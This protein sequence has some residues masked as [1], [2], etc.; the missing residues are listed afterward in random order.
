MEK[1][2][3]L[4]E[5]KP[6]P[7]LVFGY[8]RVSTTDQNTERQKQLLLE[9]FPNQL[10]RIYEDTASGK[11]FNHRPNFQLLL[12]TVRTNDTIVVESFSR[13]SRNSADL[14]KL[15]NDFEEKQIT[16]ISL[17]ENFDFKTPTGK[18]M[19]TLLVGLT[20][21]ERELLLERQKEGILL[22]KAAGKYKGRKKIKKPSNFEDCLKMYLNREN[23]YRIK[24]FMLDTGLK[25][26]SVFKFIKERK[27]K[28]F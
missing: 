7:N 23:N 6:F 18:L 1:L 24:N 21:M 20:Q 5:L 12:E 14:L 16:L 11:S 3:G 13:I 27:D 28:L 15:L 10:T 26:S 9:K 19:L 2:P 4:Y 22:A 17:K 25:R 8:V